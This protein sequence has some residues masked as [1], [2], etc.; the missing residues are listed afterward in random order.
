MNEPAVATDLHRL[1]H[2]VASLTLGEHTEYREGRLVLSEEEARAP[3]RDPALARV[4]VACA[5]PG[6][7]V[8]IVNP[9]DAV[10]PCTKGP[11]GAGVFP[12]FIGPALPPGRG[13]TH[14]L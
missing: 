9:L 5:S 13:E 6:E 14:I 2:E 10:Q 11:G 4:R 12:G 8:R 1:V 7:S 3:F